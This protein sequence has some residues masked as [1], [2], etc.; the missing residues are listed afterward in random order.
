MN[1]GATF[2]R[3]RDIAVSKEKDR[4]VVIYLDDITIYSKSDQDYLKHLK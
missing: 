4:F 1:A 3:E 2:Q